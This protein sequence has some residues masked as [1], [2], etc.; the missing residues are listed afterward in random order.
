MC[1]QYN[2]YY[3]HEKV[4]KRTRKYLPFK[5]TSGFVVNALHITWN[6]DLLGFMIVVFNVN[7]SKSQF[8]VNATK[9]SFILL[10]VIYFEIYH[11]KFIREKQQMKINRINCFNGYTVDNKS[12]ITT[13]I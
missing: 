7:Q 6:P 5:L 9:E 13:D 1:D 3:N 11:W 10:D 12:K 4:S 2:K 8:T